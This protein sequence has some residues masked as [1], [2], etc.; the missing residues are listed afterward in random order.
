[1]MSTRPPFLT[2][3]SL[4]VGTLICSGQ[5]RTVGP[6]YDSRPGQIPPVVR[7]SPRPVTSMDLLTLRDLKGVRISPDG[8]RVAFVVSQAV[9]ETNGYQTGLF[10]VGTE[11]G[12]R[13]I[14]L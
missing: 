13:A 9:Y 5:T 10:V 14:S 12:S 7:S 3:V 6:G 11:P 8:R 2:I 4:F 1:M